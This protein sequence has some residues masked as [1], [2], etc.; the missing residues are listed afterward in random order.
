MGSKEL[1][2][3]IPSLQEIS[4]YVHSY[5]LSHAT[6]SEV[7]VRLY[8]ECIVIHKLLTSGSIHRRQEHKLPR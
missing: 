2:K 1:A 3:E 4:V 8:Y 7:E 6:G 5:D